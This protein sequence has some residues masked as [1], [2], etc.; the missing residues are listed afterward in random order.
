M[1][2]HAAH[3]DLLIGSQVGQVGHAVRRKALEISF[4]LRQRM[5]GEIEVERLLF[6]LQLF[7]IRPFGNVG[8]GLDGRRGIGPGTLEDVEEI[9]LAGAAVVLNFA[10]RLQRLRQNV[11]PLRPAGLEAIE[12]AGLDQPLDRG[13][14]NQ[15]EIDTL[16]E[17]EE[18]PVG[19]SFLA[20][21][22]RMRHHVDLSVH[23]ISAPDHDEVGDAH[24]ARIDAGNL[25]GADRKPDPGDVG[26]NGGVEAGIFLYMRKA[27][28]AVAH[29]EPHGAGIIVGPDRL[30]AEFAFGRVEAITY[31]VQRLVPG[32]PRELS[33]ALC[34]GAT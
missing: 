7:A 27:V 22:D 28:D 31:F 12:G 13:S 15:L 32:N 16:A 3:Q 30:S 18:V 26:A 19:P 34:A 11:H 10:C 17:I 8:Q 14:R 24:L 4:M 2:E 23:G 25:A 29:H 1:R 20:G 21:A 33:G 6:V 5:A 9:A